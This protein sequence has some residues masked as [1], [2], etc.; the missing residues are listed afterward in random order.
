MDGVS[1]GDEG[2]IPCSNSTMMIGAE[3]Q[4]SAEQHQIFSRRKQGQSSN[5]RPPGKRPVVLDLQGLSKYFAISQ[6]QACVELGIGLSTMKRL[7]RKLGIK[8]WPRQADGQAQKSGAAA[9]ASVQ[10]SLNDAS[11]EA[12]AFSSPMVEDKNAMQHEIIATS[13]CCQISGQQQQ[14]IASC[15]DM[16]YDSQSIV[17]QVNHVEPQW[18]TGEHQHQH[19]H[20]LQHQHQHQRWNMNSSHPQHGSEEVLQ[21][22]DPP[23][24]AWHSDVQ[25]EHAQQSSMMLA[26]SH[27]AR[28]LLAAHHA[29]LAVQHAQTDAGH[30]LAAASSCY[31]PFPV[32]WPSAA[33]APPSSSS[34]LP[35]QAPLKPLLQHHR[36][37]HREHGRRKK[38]RRL[39]VE[40]GSEWT[41]ELAPQSPSQ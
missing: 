23:S 4:Q 8:S 32:P 41:L 30:D 13:H 40:G 6:Q 14:L 39:R 16:Q 21:H 29:L 11:S 24:S 17:V 37:R 22:V 34:S 28:E 27:G 35:P 3:Q 26:R 2:D 5:G 12:A 10:F 1:G 19:Q 38:E 18:S 9:V 15:V 7:C 25:L 36:H 31:S 33:S 20:Q